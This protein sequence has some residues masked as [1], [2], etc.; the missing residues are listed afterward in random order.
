LTAKALGYRVLSNDVSPAGEA[1][2]KALIEN[3]ETTLNIPDLVAA[4]ENEGID[5]LPDD[6]ALAYPEVCRDLL[7]RMAGAE[8]EA[9][10]RKRWLYRAWIVKTA[11]GLSAWG[12]P[13]MS[14]GRKEADENN[15]GQAARI[16]RTRT[17]LALAVRAAEKLNRGVF[18]NGQR[19]EA[20][21]SDALSW[22]GENAG[23]VDVAYLDPPYP[24]TMAYETVYQGINELLDPEFGNTPSDWSRHDGWELLEEALKAA[25][26][27]PLVIVSMGRGADPRRIHDMMESSG[28]ESA[29][30]SVAH[31]HLKTL[32]AANDPDGDELLLVG[33]KP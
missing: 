4:V 15:P 3:N 22:L 7:G 27:V 23:R 10:G 6:R 5:N 26:S 33:R 28:R 17:P 8:R 32:K 24:G 30:W 13:T 11:L 9:T 31:K 14:T 2:A 21:R 25:D 29:W 18:T 20:T 1:V 12:K 16:M 19:N